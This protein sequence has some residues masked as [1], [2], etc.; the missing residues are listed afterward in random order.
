MAQLI[1]L[2]KLVAVDMVLHGRLFILT[3]FAVG[4]L[5]GLGLG[6]FFLWTSLSS[7]PSILQVFLVFL[8]L[9]SCGIA[10]NY[11]PLLFYAISIANSGTVKAEGKPELL[12][13]RRYNIQ[14]FIVFVPFLVAIAAIAQERSRRRRQP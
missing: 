9:W 10:A 12:H 8:G 7:S 13:V 11:T 1:D 3:E 6:G 4:V 14:Q 5:L 2:R